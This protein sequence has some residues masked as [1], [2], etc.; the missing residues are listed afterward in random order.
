MYLRSL[1]GPEG[2]LYMFYDQPDLVHDIM[3]VWFELAD[4]VIAYHQQ[5]VVLD[6]LFLAEDI[7]YNHGLL[8][9]PDM[10]REFLFPYYQ[11]LITNIKAR[12]RNRKLFIKIDTDGNCD[13][14]IPLYK[15]IGMEILMPFEVAAGSDVVE[16]RKQYPDLLICGGIDKRILAAGKEAI[17]REVDRIMP[18]MKKHGGY[19]PTCDHGVPEEVDFEDY[20]YYRELMAG[21]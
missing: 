9:S 14:A 6:E 3:R 17:K 1:V 20:V 15:E 11:Q 18:F 16:V 4:A 19:M 12:N 21:Y 2:A 10:V 13:E 5:E 8:V 7:C